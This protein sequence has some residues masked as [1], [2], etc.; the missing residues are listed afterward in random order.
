MIG[1][2]DDRELSV[3]R[4]RAEAQAG[5]DYFSE[6]PHF[7]GSTKTAL[8]LTRLAYQCGMR[9]AGKNEGHEMV[10]L[11]NRLHWAKIEIA[12]KAEENEEIKSL[13]LDLRWARFQTAKKE[14]IKDQEIKMLRDDL[15]TA[16][17]ALTTKNEND[18]SACK[19][20]Q[21]GDTKM[22]DIIAAH[23]YDVRCLQELEHE[24]TKNESL[25]KLLEEKSIREECNGRKESCGSA[26]ED[27]ELQSKIGALQCAIEVIEQQFKLQCDQLQCQCGLL[28]TQ[29]AKTEQAAQEMKDKHALELKSTEQSLTAKND[30]LSA[31]LDKEKAKAE[32][33]AKVHLELESMIQH[34]EANEGSSIESLKKQHAQE[35][36]A[37]TA[38]VGSLIKQLKP[39]ESAQNDLHEEI[40]SLRSQNQSLERQR[41][42]SQS[43]S[44]TST[45]GQSS[46]NDNPD[47]MDYITTFEMKLK[48]FEKSQKSVE[49]LKVKFEKLQKSEGELKVKANKLEQELSKFNPLKRFFTDHDFSD[50]NRLELSWEE[51]TY[52]MRAAAVGL[53]PLVRRSLTPGYSAYLVEATLRRGSDDLVKYSDQSR[54]RYI[55]KAEF[56]EAVESVVD[57]I[58]WEAQGFPSVRKQL[59]DDA[60]TV[61]TLLS[62]DGSV[63]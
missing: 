52:A 20:Q 50:T 4:I 32:K 5:V 17:Q 19:G 43:Q 34:R 1:P 26:A 21:I 63:E 22:N 48:R 55:L 37:H 27:E 46:T 40:A 62:E 44:S 30:K 54:G 31:Q 51:M 11:D 56:F 28:Q 2:Q 39:K 3:E 41:E 16:R 7:A 61:K 10:A 60:E 24:K 15:H 33:Q 36:K 59:N 35:I 53:S 13:R 38:K 12:K 9:D 29:L 57:S 49:E 6:F 18:P 45:N 14:E 23:S 47:H 25:Q 58:L 8:A 42:H